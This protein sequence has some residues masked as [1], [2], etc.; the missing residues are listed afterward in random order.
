MAR[1][2]KEVCALKD[3]NSEVYCSLYKGHRYR[4]EAYEY[5]N[6]AAS[7]LR[8]WGGIEEF[9]EGITDYDNLPDATYEETRR[10]DNW[11]KLK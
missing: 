6:V 8:A 5:D 3:S 2:A 7:M 11:D 1:W 4:H 9:N 10:L